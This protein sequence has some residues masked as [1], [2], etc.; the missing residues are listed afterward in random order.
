MVLPPQGLRGT[1]IVPSD[2]IR[3]T[4]LN[5]LIRKE[6][7]RIGVTGITGASD[8]IDTFYQGDKAL[9]SIMMVAPAR[10]IRTVVAS[11]IV[12]ATLD[13]RPVPRGTRREQELCL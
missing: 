1:W 4:P 12:G 7:C 6:L 8:R 9:A 13:E 11:H 3:S 10:G 5:I 2:Q